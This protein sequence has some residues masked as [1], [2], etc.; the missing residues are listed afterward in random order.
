[1][2][3]QLCESDAAVGGPYCAPRHS[4]PCSACGVQR[5]LT[6]VAV[7]DQSHLIEYTPASNWERINAGGHMLTSDVVFQALR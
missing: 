4:P 5:A 6:N 7:D 3:H 2:G 1:M